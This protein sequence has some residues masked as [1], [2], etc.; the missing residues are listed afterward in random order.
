MSEMFNFEL[1]KEKYLV[2]FKTTG[3]YF[4]H[5]PSGA[6]LLSFENEDEN[7]QNLGK[8]ILVLKVREEGNYEYKTGRWIGS[9]N[10]V[11]MID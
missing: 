1:V 2:E 5:I 9:K 6:E 7:C 4:K 11:K 10:T 3:R 8:E